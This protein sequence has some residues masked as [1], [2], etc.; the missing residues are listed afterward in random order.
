MLDGREDN[1][2]GDQLGLL[3]SS[4]VSLRLWDVG[5]SNAAH[6]WQAKSLQQR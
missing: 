5:P 1:L 6:E 3:F 2:A 4:L